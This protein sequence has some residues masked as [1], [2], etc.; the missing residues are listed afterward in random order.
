VVALEFFGL[1]L[2]ALLFGVRVYAVCLQIKCRGV[3]LGLLWGV[4]VF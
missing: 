2:V 4:C 1:H 3:S